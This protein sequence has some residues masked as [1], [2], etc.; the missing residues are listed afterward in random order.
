[1]KFPVA[2]FTDRNMLPGL[3]VAVLSLLE[4]VSDE[5]ARGLTIKIFLDQVSDREVDALHQTVRS[6]HRGE[7]EVTYT[8]YSPTAPKGGSLLHGN[9][10]IY[11]RLCLPKLLPSHNHCLYL[12]SDLIVLCDIGE[13]FQYFDNKNILLADGAGVRRFALESRLLSRA[14]LDME[15]PYF[16]SGVLGINLALWRKR[17]A[18]DL[19]AKV[20]AKFGGDMTNGDQALLNLALHDSFKSLGETYNTQIFPWSPPVKEPDRRIYHFVGSPKPWDFLGSWAS[21]HYTM[22]H[23][24]YRRTAI[25]HRSPLCY[26]SLLRN[27]RI[28]RQFIRSGVRRHKLLRAGGKAK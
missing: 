24:I 3:H 4:S 11:G 20:L 9:H 6:S 8:A 7:V 18:D 13:I 22:W 27:L 5:T 1:M 16:N 12:D 28:T 23:D 21:S 14:G 25:G 19:C 17:N 2:F 26:S 15:G 10:T